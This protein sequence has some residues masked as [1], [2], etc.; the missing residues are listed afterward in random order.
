MGAFGMKALAKI[1]IVALT[2]VS[3]SACVVDAGRG[4]PGWHHDWR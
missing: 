3:V 4:G 2:V 1:A